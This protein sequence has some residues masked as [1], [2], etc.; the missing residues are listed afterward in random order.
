MERIWQLCFLVRVT[1]S[2]LNGLKWPFV[3]VC[4]LSPSVLQW[5]RFLGLDTK[6]RIFQLIYLN[7]VYKTEIKAEISFAGQ[8]KT[9]SFVCSLWFS[10]FIVEFLKNL[11]MHNSFVLIAEQ[12]LLNSCK[13]LELELALKSKHITTC[14]SVQHGNPELSPS[15]LIL[16]VCCSSKPIHFN[17]LI[18]CQ[19]AEGRGG[20]YRKADRCDARFFKGSAADPISAG[21]RRMR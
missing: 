1:Q 13:K 10:V 7:D 21:P 6:S 15:F 20:K 9:R 4:Q 3:S 5:Y 19:V 17:W 8:N 2:A 18:A 16:S 14:V 12:F 11:E